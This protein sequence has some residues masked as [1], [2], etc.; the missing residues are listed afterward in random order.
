MGNQLC[1]TG[2]WSCPST[3]QRKKKTG[4]QARRA[5]RQQ[6]QQQ[7]QHLL[8]AHDTRGPIYEQVL[9]KPATQE[10]SPG[11]RLKE[12]SLH[13]ADIQVCSSTQPRS[14]WEVKHLQSENATQY[15]TLRFPQATPRY[16]SKNGTLV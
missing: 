2:S 8:Q 9:E 6:Q 11:L 16:D 1:C 7:Q 3:S 13:Y 4:S 10:R 14:A 15:A 12:S 5:P